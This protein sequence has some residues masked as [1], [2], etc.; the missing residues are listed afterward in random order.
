MLHTVLCCLCRI[1]LYFIV[2]H[3]ILFYYTVL[4]SIVFPFAVFNFIL[5]PN[6]LRVVL[7]DIMEDVLYL[8]WVTK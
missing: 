5:L 6:T 7:Y 4:Y 1:A 3:S 8:D 2:L